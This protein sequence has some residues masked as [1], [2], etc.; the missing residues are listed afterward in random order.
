MVTKKKRN[1]FGNKSN[2]NSKTYIIIPKQF[3]THKKIKF[4]NEFVILIW[5]YG[6]S[7][8]NKL[9]YLIKIAWTRL[10]L[11]LTLKKGKNNIQRR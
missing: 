7:N 11:P 8:K 3:G 2:L 10:G 6:L 4:W 9:W 1:T 5:N